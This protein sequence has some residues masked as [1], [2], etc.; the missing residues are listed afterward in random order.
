MAIVTK[1]YSNTSKII[2]FLFYSRL[3]NAQTSDV[4]FNESY[5]DSYNVYKK[6][7]MVIHNDA[8]SKCTVGQFKRFLCNSSLLQTDTEKEYRYGAFHQQYLIDDKIVAVGVIDIL[9]SCV[10]SVY[11]YYDPDYAFL[12]PGT[13]TS[14]FEIAFT[15]KLQKEHF[16]NLI[17]Y[18]MGF[19][20]HSCPKM[21]YK[22]KYTPSWLLCPVT[23]RWV[24][25]KDAV[26]LLDKSK[27]AKLNIQ[28]GNGHSGDQIDV[29]DVLIL[30]EN[31]AMPFRHY[32]NV[33]KV[34]EFE[35]NEV[36]EYSNLIGGNLSK[37]ILLYR[38]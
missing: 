22:A 14:L 25:V 32:Q 18:Y 34:N 3:V 1:K 19:Y 27:F 28:D 2:L 24:S 33:T 6:Y 37:K 35:K 7:Q 21:R 38:G 15:R 16:P 31:Q 17:H 9:P 23:Y 8:P 10:S 4:T 12:S 26:P 13:L 11:L 29:D 30:Y 36:M 20:I 5:I